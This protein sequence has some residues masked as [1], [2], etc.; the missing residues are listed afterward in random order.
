MTHRSLLP[1]LTL[2]ALAVPK[3]ALPQTPISA[4]WDIIANG[5][6]GKLNI[7]AD[8]QGNIAGTWT[9]GTTTTQVKG[10]WDDRSQKITFVRTL[11]SPAVTQTYTGYVFNGSNAAFCP[12]GSY[13]LSQTM[14]G[15]F[16]YFQSTG[17]TSS[18]NTGG[19][20]ARN[21]QI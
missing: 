3:L 2:I 21:C 11:G 9:E 5:F 6:Q 13:S 12:P 16:Q 14:A 17:G 7:S 8:A 15:T 4:T 1:I 20:T 10:L 19:W 18:R